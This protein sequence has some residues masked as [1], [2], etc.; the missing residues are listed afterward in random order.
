MKN[1]TK[2]QVKIMER[3]YKDIYQAKT[4]QTYE[5][6]LKANYLQKAQWILDIEMEKQEQKDRWLENRKNIVYTYTNSNTL[7]AL[8]KKGYIKILEDTA[9]HQSPSYDKVKVIKF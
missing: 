4:H 3:A 1:L 6:Y 9:G 5:E 7:R 8:E 2:T